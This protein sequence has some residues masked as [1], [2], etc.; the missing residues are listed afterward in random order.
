MHNTTPSIHTTPHKDTRY[1]QLATPIPQV[2]TLVLSPT[3]KGPGPCILLDQTPAGP[4]SYHD[5][6][7]TLFP[8]SKDP[9][10]LHQTDSLACQTLSRSQL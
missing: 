6:K 7:N 3:S 2:A 5:I 4:I 1:L 8:T 10:I 9:Y